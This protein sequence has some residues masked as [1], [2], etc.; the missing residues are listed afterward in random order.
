MSKVLETGRLFA[1]K[2]RILQ[3]LGKGGFGAVYRACQENIPRDVALKVMLHEDAEESLVER[4]RREAL[5]I[6]QLKHPNTITL[7]DFGF[8]EGIYYLVMELLEGADLA[9]TIDT[10]GALPP[11]RAHRICAQI[12]RSL[13]EAHSRGIIHRDLKP[14]NIFLVDMPG[15]PDFIKVLDFGIARHK[16]TDESE[17]LTVDGTVVGTPWYMAPEQAL[18]REV[19]T[20]TDVYAV[21]LILYEM[22]SGRQ[23][24]QGDTLYAVLN[25]Q[26]TEAI[27]R[28]PGALADSPY[29]RLIDT[30]CAKKEAQRF[31]DA[32]SF[33]RALQQIDPR[34]VPAQPIT[35]SGAPQG[36]L[37]AGTLIVGAP[38]SALEG[39]TQIGDPLSSAVLRGAAEHPSPGESARPSR[40]LRPPAARGASSRP[41]RAPEE[42]EPGTIITSLVGEEQGTVITSPLGD[43]PVGTV[44]TA[45]PEPSPGA[46]RLTAPP[47]ARP[48]GLSWGQI[49]APAGDGATVMVSSSS[50]MAKQ[51]VVPGAAPFVG[52]EEE[53]RTLQS[54]VEYVTETRALHVVTIDGEAGVGK[55]RLWEELRDGLRER[56]DVLVLSAGHSRGG[57]PLEALRQITLELLSPEHD[58][59]EELRILTDQLV[60]QHS[61][62]RGGLGAFVGDFFD[63]EAP[64]PNAGML[65]MEAVQ[66]L[67]SLLEQVIRAGARGRVL[68]MGLDDMQWTDELT[69]YFVQFLC[70]RV[71]LEQLPLGVVLMIR[72]GVVFGAP[73][74][75][76][77]LLRIGLNVGERSFNLRLSRLSPAELRALVQGLASVDDAAL[78]AL[79]EMSHGN[80]WFTEQTLRHAT[81]SGALSW[82]EGRWVP[83]A[84]AME[85]PPALVA[86]VEMALEPLIPTEPDAE[87]LFWAVLQWI[88]LLGG[89][90]SVTAVRTGLRRDPRKPGLREFEPMLQGMVQMGLVSRTSQGREQSLQL[91][92]PLLAPVVLTLLDEDPLGEDV[93]EF[94]KHL[95]G[96]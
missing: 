92:P 96:S 76:E 61:A 25:R 78:D 63:P 8:D 89:S 36:G 15:E 18:G 57:A 27:G 66:A 19:T 29:Q 39:A 24:F 86:R 75:T 47:Q 44:I 58:P 68:L 13:N 43:A 14:E 17:R 3:I 26:V 23:A 79:W 95:R 71:H 7:F 20:A 83:G 4:F 53:L 37:E 42:A 91:A 67:F 60:Y 85:P 30:A 69:A 54:L 1:G 70:E 34:A 21:G 65:D 82:S 12:L 35:P 2:Y 55:T 9:H 73:D 22:L 52:R 32:A 10:Y 59:E 51:D 48:R 84:Q 64:I 56:A 77:A 6:S 93:R 72:P 45:A 90:A 50:G 40:P 28:L 62:A 49:G 38:S 11:E 74:V 94:A 33:L 81:R 80:P 5:H 31:S 16:A 41:M 87:R 88:A 46:G